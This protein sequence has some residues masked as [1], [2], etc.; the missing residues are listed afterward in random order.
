MLLSDATTPS[1]STVWLVIIALFSVGSNVATIILAIA[2]FRKQRTEVT[3]SPNYLTK[4]EFATHAAADQKDSSDQWGEI[5]QIKKDISQI[6]DR[7]FAL[8][9]NAGVIERKNH[10]TRN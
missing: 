2:A 9:A 5:N 3:F 6:P 1:I 10:G 8:L 4:H 7:L